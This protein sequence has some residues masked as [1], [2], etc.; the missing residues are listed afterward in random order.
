MKYDFDKVIDRH[1]T[2]S[3]KWD[4]LPRMSQLGW[5]ENGNDQTIPMMTAD[6]D[7]QSPQPVIE[8]MHRVADHM[9]YGYSTH[10][11]DPA[12][13]ASLC[14]WFADR[15]GWQIRP[16]EVICSHGTF[17]ALTHV[18]KMKAGEGQGVILFT[19]VYGH[20]SQD[21][22]AWGRKSVYCHLINN[23]GYYTIDFEKLERLAADPNNT[24][25]IFC[26]PHNPVGRVWTPEE[27]RRVS[28]ICEKH[29]VFVISDEV[30]CDHLRKGVRYTPFLKACVNKANAICLVGVNKSFNMAGLSCS[31]A[32]VQD[33]Q[34]HAEI[35]KDYPLYMPTPFAVAG[36]IAAYTEGDEWMDQVCEYIE[37][38]MDWALSFFQKEMPRLVIAKPQ[39]T[40][41][42]WMDF[43]AYGLTEQEIHKRI[44]TDANVFLQDGTV[45]DPDEGQ[46]FQRMCVP[47][48]RS[49]LMTACRRI[50][51]AFRDV[52]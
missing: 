23:R 20:F 35:M 49:V 51:A 6:M 41:C 31:N 42:L 48:A 5:G 17:G 50:A 12:Y 28:E 37:G 8:A 13:A 39:G 32:I 22:T 26:N 25:L 11:S 29:G 19:P 24:L 21:V 43:S 46:C 9:M 4:L 45:H 10:Q 14:R 15:H 2:Y 38:N 27:I 16:D 44:Y 34:L 7:L 52:E 33:R 36:Q 40:Y 3:M 18:A 47:C 30:H 1:G